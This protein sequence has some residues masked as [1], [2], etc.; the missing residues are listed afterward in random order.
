MAKYKIL[1]MMCGA[2][3]S[4]K[5]TWVR[6]HLD[7]NS[8]VISRDQIRFNMVKEDEYYFSKEDDVFRT[9]I[10]QIQNA[11]NDENGPDCIY[12][13]A[14]HMTENGRNKVLDRLRL[15]NVELEAVVVMPS[16]TEVLRRNE[17][18][19]GREKVPNEAVV[20]MYR[21]YEDPR[22][23]GKHPFK[24]ITMVT[25]GITYDIWNIK[26]DNNE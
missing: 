16:L 17:Q 3:G 24:R 8:I 6:N 4:G 11:I 25:E 18:R 22:F 5:S 7:N 20:R 10:R 13:D 21:S 14:T 1:K 2:P 23:D 12:C 26:G 15:D 9:F 19:Q